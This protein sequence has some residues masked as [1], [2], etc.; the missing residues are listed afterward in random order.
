MFV[1]SYEKFW[2]CVSSTRIHAE[3]A[4]SVFCKWDSHWACLL[5]L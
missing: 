1:T 2:V 5:Q 4:R 3:R